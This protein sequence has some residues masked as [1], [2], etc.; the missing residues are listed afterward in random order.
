MKDL[1]NEEL[2]SKVCGVTNYGIEKHT[3]IAELKAELLSRIKRGE[4]AEKAM[5][6]IVNECNWYMSE[7]ADD[8]IEFFN[9]KIFNIIQ[10]YTEA[11]NE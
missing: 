8:K 3:S 2:V 6:K 10:Q 9:S 4:A 11:G 1:S 7:I 5:E